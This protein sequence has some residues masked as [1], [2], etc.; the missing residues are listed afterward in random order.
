MRE[1]DAFRR[2]GDVAAE[3]A[4]GSG[5]LD[6]PDEVGP[7]LRDGHDLLADEEVPRALGRGVVVGAG[8]G[9][10]LEEAVDVGERSD[11]DAVA[12]LRSI[13]R[14]LRKAGALVGGASLS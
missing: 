2:A 3:D 12:T 7:T 8:T 5:H 1:A 14:K 9:Q 4:R 13:Q 10:A 11:A 6:V